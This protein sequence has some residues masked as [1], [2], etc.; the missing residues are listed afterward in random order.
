MDEQR[1]VQAAQSGDLS[2]FNRLVLSYQELAYNVAYR[3]LD[4]PEGAADAAQDGFLKAYR[5]LK[6]YRG[7]SFRA[8]LL[9]IVTN[10][11]Y[12]ALRARRRRPTS[13][14][15]VEDHD[16]DYDGR[17]RDRG[18]SPDEFVMRQE[19]AQAIQAAIADLP[20]EQRA[21]LVLCDVEGLDYQE[22]AGITGA[23]LGTVKSRLWRA[24]ARVREILLS[25][26]DLFW[27]EL[28]SQGRSH[29]QS[30]LGLA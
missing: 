14:L 1:L 11:C 8:W 26:K 29:C 13:R 22:I 17:L 27:G 10:T 2:A 23:A 24:R 16:P 28:P 21:V 12:D 19:L 15:E 30:R 6:Q 18:E 3:L 20:Q 4:D 7:G 9:R 5:C 25:Q